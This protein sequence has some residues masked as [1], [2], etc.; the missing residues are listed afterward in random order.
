MLLSNGNLSETGDPWTTAATSPSGTTLPKPSYLFALVAADLVAR[1][2]SAPAPA[3]PPAAGVGAPGD[4]DKTEH[5]MN[6]LIASIIWDEAR[7]R[8]W[9]STWNV[10]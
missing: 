1:E 7:F 6:S 4:L 5:A 8:S 10:S 9:R 3:G 2:Q